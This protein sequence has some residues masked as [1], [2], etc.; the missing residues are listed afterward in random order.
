MEGVRKGYLLSKMVYKRVGACAIP[1]PLPSPCGR[2]PPM[3]NSA[4]QLSD[5]LKLNV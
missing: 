2:E 4:Q 3:R 5:D 1:S